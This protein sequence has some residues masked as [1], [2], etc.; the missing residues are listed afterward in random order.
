MLNVRP[1]PLNVTQE[2]DHGSRKENMPSVLVEP[3]TVQ[4]RRGTCG[5]VI[6][7]HNYGRFLAEAF[8]SVLAQTRLPD[9]VVIIND[10]STDDSAEI[11]DSLAEGRPWVRV[12]HRSPAGGAPNTFN[13]GIRSTSTDYVVVLSAD[14]RLSPSYLE[15]SAQLLDEGA[16]VAL[17]ALKRFGNVESFVPPR[18][19][20]LDRTLIANEHHGSYLMRRSVFD[21]VGGYSEDVTRE[22]WDFWVCAMTK[23]VTGALAPECWVEYRQHGPSRN[24]MSKWAGWRDRARIWKR[25]HR[26]IGTMR[27]LRA[28]VREAGKRAFAR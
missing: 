21:L 25:H 15:R 2:D 13:L 16:D 6:P 5:V 24:Q 26:N 19:F 10:G 3:Q 1:N 9:E 23:G 8:G 7:C 4:T 17:S 14:D 27:L 20:D 22:D 18:D 12:L 28:L 11:A